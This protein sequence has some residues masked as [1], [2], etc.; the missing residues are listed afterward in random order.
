MPS[1]GSKRGRS[2]E[3]LTHASNDDMDENSQYA[4]CTTFKAG[5][6]RCITSTVERVA[7]PAS[8]SS[9]RASTPRGARASDPVNIPTFDNTSFGY[10]TETIGGVQVITL[11]PQDARAKQVRQSPLAL[12]RLL[13]FVSSRI[14]RRLFRSRRISTSISTSSRDWTVEATTRPRHA[15]AHPVR[16]LEIPPTA[17]PNATAVSSVVTNA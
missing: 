5:P 10:V 3:D 14:M 2:P 12:C 13:I 15:P 11:R 16:D 7:H 6:R 17:V 4:V 8:S 9:A 1:R